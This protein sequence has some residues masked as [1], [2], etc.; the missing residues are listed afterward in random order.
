[1]DGPNTLY[2]G[3]RTLS[4][5]P[6]S[7]VDCGAIHVSPISDLP[8]AHMTVISRGGLTRYIKLKLWGIALG[9]AKRI[10]FQSR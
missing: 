6:Y 10:V 4:A 5:I 3:F 1:M 9:Q 7:F 2:K 8:N